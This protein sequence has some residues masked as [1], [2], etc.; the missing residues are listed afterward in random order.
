MVL[1]T[2][3]ITEVEP[4]LFIGNIAS[5]LDLDTIRDNGITAIVSLLGTSY[6]QRNNP[7]V[8][9]LIPEEKHLFV[10]CEDSNV[11]DLLVHLSDICDFID[12]QLYPRKA[13]DKETQTN[14]VTDQEPRGPGVL[15]HC[16]QGISRS[17]TVAIA[18]LM[19]KRGQGNDLVLR[20]VEK[21]RNIHP[22]DNFV[23]QLRVWGDVNYEIWRDEAKRIP[24][25]Q[26]AAY[27]DGRATRIK[28]RGLNNKEALEFIN[29]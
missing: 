18:Y 11:M 16:E 2:P 22:L 20:E 23:D 8:R 19:R 24:T 9:N 13:H 7:D 10:P 1:V 6:T 17:P 28:A 25:R 21:K 4:H 27:L 3:S 12:E 5:S 26:Y 29:S 15:I 14:G